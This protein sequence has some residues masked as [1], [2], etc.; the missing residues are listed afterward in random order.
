MTL[1]APFEHVPWYP[2]VFPIFWGAFALFAIFIARRLR[3]FTAVHADGGPVASAEL[4]RRAWGL[5][6]YAI[7]QSKMFKWTQSGVIHY[8]VFLGSTILL[9]ANI[10]IVTGGLLQAVVGWPLDGTFWTF[11]VALQN[12]IAVGVLA[13]LVYLFYRRLVLRPSR[14]SLDRTGLQILTMIFL[15]VSTEFVAL[16]FEAARYGPIPGAFVTNALAVPLE[17]LGSAVTE[18]GFVAFWWAHVVRARGRSSCSSRRTSTSTST[19]ASSTSGSASSGH[20]A[21]CPRWTSRTRPR[22]SG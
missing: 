14:L 5:V 10:N 7:F 21:S 1:F 16:A 8:V 6:R 22:R 4:G 12:I 13:S 18:A 2:L 15:V 9:T 19:R 11:L 3:V 17:S 20:A